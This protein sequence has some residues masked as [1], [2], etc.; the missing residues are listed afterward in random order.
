MLEVSPLCTKKPTISI[1]LMGEIQY[2]QSGVSA[3]CIICVP[4]CSLCSFVGDIIHMLVF[5]DL[6]FGPQNVG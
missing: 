3:G 6:K 2:D 5:S 4:M 1:H